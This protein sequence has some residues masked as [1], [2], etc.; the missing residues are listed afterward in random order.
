MFRVIMLDTTGRY[1]NPILKALQK[2]T[3]INYPGLGNSRKD[4]V[5]QPVNGDR[6]PQRPALSDTGSGKKADSVGKTDNKGRA[7]SV[8]RTDNGRKT[9]SEKKAG[10]IG[11]PDTART[12]Q[13]NKKDSTQ[14]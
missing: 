11:K 2:N 13:P 9:D 1:N 10:S 8:K 3:I 7:D 14:K 12:T 6:P 4:P 5:D